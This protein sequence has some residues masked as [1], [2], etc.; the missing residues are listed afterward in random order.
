MLYIYAACV[1]YNLYILFTTNYNILFNSNE[2]GDLV[3]FL[4]VMIK[5][6]PLLKQPSRGVF[7]KR[8]SKNMQQI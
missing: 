1:H 8:Y 6:N 4:G 7:R 3:S 2:Q 5:V